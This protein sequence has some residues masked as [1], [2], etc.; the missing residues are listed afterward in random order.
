[1]GEKKYKIIEGS[2]TIASGMNLDMAL[3]F[4][5][6]YAETYYNQQLNLIIR[7]E[8]QIKEELKS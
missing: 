6:G 5:R 3:C 7:E 2:T 1:M 4:I 8:S